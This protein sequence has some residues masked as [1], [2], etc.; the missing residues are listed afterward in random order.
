V[1]T[2]EARVELVYAIKVVVENPEGIFK[3]GMPVEGYLK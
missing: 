2:R 3:I 1:Q